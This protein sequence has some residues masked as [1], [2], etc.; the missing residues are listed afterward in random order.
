MVMVSIIT[1]GYSTEP[2]LRRALS[3]CELLEYLE[4]TGIETGVAEGLNSY[5]KL[6]YT[7]ITPLEVYGM[8]LYTCLSVCPPIR[9]SLRLLSYYWFKLHDF[10]YLFL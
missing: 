5:L 10:V 6:Y 3:K 9:P 7:S 8:A 4:Y 1:L 2:S